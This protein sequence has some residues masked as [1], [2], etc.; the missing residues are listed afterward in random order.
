MQELK[1]FV[2]SGA[3]STENTLDKI[4]ERFLAQFSSMVAPIR[5]NIFFES[6]ARL[7]INPI[8]NAAIFFTGKDNI[9][10][11]VERLRGELLDSD[12][13]LFAT[14]VY[15]RQISGISK[16]FLDRLA[17]WTHLMNLIGKLAVPIVMSSSNG[18]KETTAYLDYIL[19]HMGAIVLE[20]LI[21]NQTELTPE[22]FEA[23]MN[24]VVRKNADIICNKKYKGSKFQLLKYLH[25]KEKWL[26]GECIPFEQNYF[27]QTGILSYDNFD[28]LFREKCHIR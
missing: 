20:P 15:L 13:V 28:S 4:I 14:P 25:L 3:N 22:L 7:N 19:Q 21:V 23:T 9:I 12:I 11:D 2:F 5:L 8:D 17:N 24:K 16:V 1:V 6:T 26:N 18:E 27:N 10:D